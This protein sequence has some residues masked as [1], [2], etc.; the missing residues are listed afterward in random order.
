MPVREKFEQY[1][2]VSSSQNSFL[3]WT[4]D[5]DHTLD[6]HSVTRSASAENGPTAPDECSADNTCPPLPTSINLN[7]SIGVRLLVSESITS[8][9]SAVPFYFQPTLGGQDIDSNL[10]LGSYRDYRFRAPNILLLQERFEHS[11]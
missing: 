2:A 6:L 8:A 1:H 3:R 11:I 7:G 9:T 10:S 4:V 5:L